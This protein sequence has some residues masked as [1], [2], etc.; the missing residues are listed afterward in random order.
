MGHTRELAFQICQEFSRFTKYLP[1]VKTKV[2]F[3]GVPITDHKTLLKDEQPNIIV[4]TPGRIKALVNSGDMKTDKVKIFV[5]D[6]CDKML[7]SLG[8]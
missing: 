2:I 6:E 5:L 7:E 4:G 1:G 8:T 3:G